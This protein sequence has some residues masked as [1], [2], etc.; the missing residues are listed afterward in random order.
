MI[1]HI[2]HCA[3]AHWRQR[4]YSEFTRAVHCHSI[5]TYE[6]ILD[7]SP[8]L[9]LVQLLLFALA[10]CNALVAPTASV[11]VVA[12]GTVA[13]VML[14]VSISAT[15]ASK[16]GNELPAGCSQPCCLYSG[17]EEVSPCMF[18]NVCIGFI[19]ALNVYA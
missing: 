1:H 7:C 13:V 3:C 10:L 8:V 19:R 14:T 2:Q 18:V 6:S 17:S 16:K 15:V 11:I 12:A 4:L 5:Y 9:T